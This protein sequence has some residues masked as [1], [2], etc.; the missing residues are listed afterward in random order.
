MQAI[1]L[2]LL[3]TI[4]LQFC[5]S[6]YQYP[7]VSVETPESYV[8][9]PASVLASLR[10]EVLDNVSVVLEELAGELNRSIEEI[11][12]ND[13]TELNVSECG[14][15]GWRRVAFLNMTDPDQSCP[16]SWREYSGNSV[17][18]CGRAQSAGASCSSV[19]YSPDGME[20]NEVCGRI[21][22]HQFATP[23]AL[24]SSISG[25]I[26]KPYVDGVSITHGSP[27]QHIWTLYGAHAEFRC[28]GQSPPSFVGD[29]FFCDTG[30]P[31]DEPTHYTLQTG[32]L[33][34]DGE[35]CLGEIHC[36][37]PSSGPWFNTTLPA[38]TT[39]DIEIR[40]C[41]DQGTSNEDTPLEL[42]E[43]YVK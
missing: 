14:G 7:V 8:C 31:S 15:Y 24:D 39:D 20:Y 18:F 1:H 37:A 11:D 9:P 42:I 29:N 33:L 4:G 35:S 34:W 27:R 30:N 25:E 28:C 32:H 2:T 10:D 16:S 36:C 26:D 17:R 3:C 19:N 22:G 6:Q 41:A 12:L 21:I 13:T 5:G 40:I 23:D 43:I 38:S